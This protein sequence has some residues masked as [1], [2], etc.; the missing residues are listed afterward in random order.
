MFSRPS[1]IWSS[2]MEWEH[3][4]ASSRGDR[5]SGWTKAC[6]DSS[7]MDDG[8]GEI[9]HGG[10]ALV[11]LVGSHGDAL[12]FLEL[13]E[14]VLDEVAP[15][16]DVAVERDGLGSP[17]MLGDDDLGAAC[18]EIGDDGVAVKG[19][20]GNQSAKGDPL[21][22]R[23]HPH[24]VEAMA[25]QQFEAHEIAKRVGERQDLGRHA[26]LRAPDGLALS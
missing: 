14:K 26:A 18:V 25:G 12:E 11:G 22:Q 23:L 24:R 3:T 5:V 21:E 1:S 20:V 16:V 8:C 2:H 10:V 4:A 13:A 9:D 7:G 17:G 19:L 15:L 6:G